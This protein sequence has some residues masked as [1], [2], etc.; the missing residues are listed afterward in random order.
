MSIRVIRKAQHKTAAW[1]GGTTTELAIHPPHSNYKNLDFNF[2]LSIAKV[3]VDTSVFTRLPGVSRTLM[4]LDGT[5]QLKHDGHHSKKLKKF[6]RD[7]FE[8]D[9]QTTSYGR[10]TDFN[11]MTRGST[12]GSLSGKILKAAETW[13][14]EP[15]TSSIMAYYVLTGQINIQTLP[16]SP[17]YAGDLVWIEITEGQKIPSI[18]AIKTTEIVVSA[19]NLP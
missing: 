4:V 6:D 7:T 13:T 17:L 2:R 3:D 9:W 8:G 12:K 11:L 15:A 18:E 19:I 10:A 5:L 1:A 14:P 16:E